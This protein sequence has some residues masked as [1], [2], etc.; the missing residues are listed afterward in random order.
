MSTIPPPRPSK[1]STPTYPTAI[2]P[3]SEAYWPTGFVAIWRYL[4]SWL[5][6]IDADAAVLAGQT[7][8]YDYPAGYSDEQQPGPPAGGA[9]G[10]NPALWDVVYEVSVT[11]TNTGE[12]YGGKGVAQLY[13]QFPQ[14]ISYDTP[15]V[16]LRDFNKTATLAPG[17]SA[18]LT[19]QLTRKDLSVWDVGMQNWIIPTVTGGY[20]V[21]IGEASDRLFLACDTSTMDCQEGLDSPV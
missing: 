10:G 21:W 20:T 4:Y 6:E 16:Q 5:D 12:T 2:P 7:L 13:L 15:V 14:G 18:V 17:E 1:G 3:A 9:Q 11:V 19:M 8:E